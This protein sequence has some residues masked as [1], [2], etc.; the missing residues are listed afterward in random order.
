MKFILKKLIEIKVK[1]NELIWNFTAPGLDLGLGCQFFGYLGFG[2]FTDLLQ[3]SKKIIKIQKKKCFCG[4]DLGI[5]F[6]N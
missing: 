5:N 2:Y 6:K 3:I 4:M 1:W